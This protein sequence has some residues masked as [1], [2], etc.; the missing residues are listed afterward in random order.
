MKNIEVDSK[1]QKRDTTT[2][3]KVLVRMCQNAFESII[4]RRPM[5]V[6]YSNE[7]S[8]FKRSC[9]NETFKHL[10]IILCTV[11]RYI[12]GILNGAVVTFQKTKKRTQEKSDHN[13][14]VYRKRSIGHCRLLI[15]RDSYSFLWF[16]IIFYRNMISR[17]ISELLK[18]KILIP[19]ILDTCVET[20]VKRPE[21]LSLECSCVILK[22]I[23]KELNHVIITNSNILRYISVR[24]NYCKTKK[25]YQL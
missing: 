12:F 3:R 6:K 20:L 11:T 14:I 1:E 8:I 5:M 15:E 23:G 7:V 24:Y 16:T 17:F 9:V 2:F 25:I 22:H 13:K 10:L 19:E 18:V 21:E 4:A